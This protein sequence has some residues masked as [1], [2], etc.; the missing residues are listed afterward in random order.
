MVSEVLREDF[1]EQGGEFLDDLLLQG[2]G[3]SVPESSG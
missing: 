3:E 2:V 1:L